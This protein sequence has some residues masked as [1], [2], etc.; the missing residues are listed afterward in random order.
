MAH[1][2]NDTNQDPKTLAH[3]EYS[4]IARSEQSRQNED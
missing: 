3:R 2:P 1:N 4:N